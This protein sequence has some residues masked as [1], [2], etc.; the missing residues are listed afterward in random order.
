MESRNNSSKLVSGDLLVLKSDQFYNDML[1]PPKPPADIEPE[2]SAMKYV[3]PLP[4]GLLLISMIATA[5]ATEHADLP[6]SRAVR[7]QLYATGF[8][9]AEGPVLDSQGNLFVVNYRFNGTIGRISAD[10]TAAIFCDLRVLAPLEGREPQ[11]TG[12][13]IDSQGRLIAADSGAG[14]LLRIA[15][16]GQSA[17]VLADRWEGKRF[18]EVNDVALDLRGNI[19]FSDPGGSVALQYAATN[20]DGSV[21]R[22][23][24][25][26]AQVS[27]LATG[28]AFP[29]GLGVTP[30][31]KHFCLSESAKYRIL[32]YDLTDEGRLA[33]G[34]VLIEFPLE[35]TEQNPNGRYLPNGMIFDTAGRLYVA[36]WTG[37]VINVVEV[38]SGKLIR[39]YDAGGP[40]ATNCHFHGGYLYVTVAAK[41]AVFRLKLGVDGFDYA[42]ATNNGP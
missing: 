19:Y 5:P 30:D 41:E 28:L 36:T 35:P 2:C 32:I 1:Y 26:T 13:K 16:D 25:K 8:E 33:N 31:Q 6:A 15:A 37:G 7:P 20:P 40:K 3:A 34:R 38:P 39:Q 11:A 42:P 18:N 10:G 23:N 27:Q 22:Y 21:Y 12:L 9:S 29:N 24:I 4:I 17:E 14:R